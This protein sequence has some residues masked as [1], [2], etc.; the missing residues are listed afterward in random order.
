MQASHSRAGGGR[1]ARALSARGAVTAET[2]VVLPVLV[3]LTLGL[4]WLV[5]LGVAQLRVVDAARETARAVARDEPADAA[6]ELGLRVAP[7]GAQ[8]HV[9]RGAG[10]VRV[11]V[12]SD[13]SP[14]RG[15]LA[16]LPAVEVDAEA[17]AA[18][19]EP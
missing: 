2:A 8:I 3:A 18:T 12:V 19:E 16:F 11:E 15:L 9:E 5:G 6:V 7:A 1:R 14:A 10:V 17:V 13:V 4:V